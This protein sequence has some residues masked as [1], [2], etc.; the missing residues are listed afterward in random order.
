M[1]YFCIKSLPELVT[2]H[3]RAMA[4]KASAMKW[5]AMFEGNTDV[6]RESLLKDQVALSKR[7]FSENVIWYDYEEVF[8]SL[9]KGVE[10][11]VSQTRRKWKPSSDM[12]QYRQEME[13]M[14]L[15]TDIVIF[16]CLRRLDFRFIPMSL[17]SRVIENLSKFTELRV[18]IISAG[19]GGQWMFKSVAHQIA[20]GMEGMKKL[21]QF[22]CKHDCTYELLE[23]LARNCSST[24]R[25][26]DVE[27]SKFVNDGCFSCITSFLNLEELNIFN[28]KLSDEAKARLLTAL[29]KL[30]NLTRGDFLCEALG[31][32]DYLDEIDDLQLLVTEFFPS[33]SYYFHEEWQ[34]EMVSRLCPFISK[35]FFIFHESCVSSYLVLVPF[36]YLNELCV[37]GGSFY[38]DKLKELLE[39]RGANLSRLSLIAVTKVDFLAVAYISK[40]CQNLKA[41]ALSNCD[42]GD[43]KPGPDP[44]SDA[45]Y[46][47]RQNYITMARLAH[48]IV[49][50][51]E[52]MEEIMIQSACRSIY[53]T[54]LI[55]RCPK[56]KKIHLGHAAQVNDETILKIYAQHG[57]CSLE[58]FHCEKSSG[59]TLN[60]LTLLLNSCDELRAVSDIQAWSG[61]TPAEVGAFRQ[62]CFDQNLELD[63]RSHQKMRKFLEMRDFERRTY[64]NMLAGPTM[65]RIRMEQRARAGQAPNQDE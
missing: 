42:V 61:V 52:N 3:V 5:Y 37:Y 33:Q 45:E 26:L 22:S 58:E 43:F 14:S 35:M 56:V 41:L 60:A 47:R 28:T 65:E 51:M 63:T 27:D 55:G 32:I 44:N 46:S 53:A 10:E 59:L 16:P 11:A 9:L 30:T 12:A 40:Y 64:M 50:V 15:F 54:F 8:K 25:V 20:K 23:V 49:Q 21:E 39:I 18:L 34:M 4:H 1:K 19:P 38:K 7:Y 2:K 17:R 6:N 13:A 24:L 36:E 62:M 31:W 29:P 48:D 57:L